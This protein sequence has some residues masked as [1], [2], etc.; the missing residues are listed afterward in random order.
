MKKQIRYCRNCNTKLK[1]NSKFCSKC[2][3][4]VHFRFYN[5][6]IFLL[7]FISSIL[8]FSVVVSYI[9]N[10][11]T[12]ATSKEIT[13]IK[14]DTYFDNNSVQNEDNQTD[15]TLD[16][17]SD[18]KTKITNI[19]EQKI[20]VTMAP[21]NRTEEKED[22][23]TLLESKII[24]LNSNK[25][26]W[27]N[28]EIRI[29]KNNKLKIGAAGK[30]RFSD[31]TTLSTPKGINV[32]WSTNTGLC[33]KITPLALVMRLKTNSTSDYHCKFVGEYLELISEYDGILEL[34]INDDIYDDNEGTYKIYV[35]VYG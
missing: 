20:V 26:L 15:I 5:E 28:T 8:I 32:S 1:S 4:R 9:N 33:P 6:I 30:V 29:Q 13:P 25:K 35:Q 19:T 34:A 7:I 14:N 18:I 12:I 10:S 21:I 3:F 11:I 31:Y 17:I 27:Y 23:I 16:N 22:E 2:G 24:E